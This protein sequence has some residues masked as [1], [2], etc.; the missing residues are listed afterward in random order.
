[1]KHSILWEH[2]FFA[3]AQ[4]ITQLALRIADAVAKCAV[5]ARNNQLRGSPRLKMRDDYMGLEF[6]AKVR[7]GSFSTE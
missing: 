4:C 2:E 7:K 3:N 5:A 1:L 6:L